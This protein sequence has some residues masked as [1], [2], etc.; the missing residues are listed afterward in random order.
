MNERLQRV[1]NGYLSLS[2]AEKTEFEKLLANREFEKAERTA[3]VQRIQKSV[4]LGP[5]TINGCPCCG[6]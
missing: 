4:A 6:K 2:E 5:V 3:S 1:L